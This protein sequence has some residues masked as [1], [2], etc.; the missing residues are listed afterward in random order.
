MRLTFQKYKESMAWDD[1]SR[2]IGDIV[3]IKEVKSLGQAFTYIEN[4]CLK[5]PFFH[6]YE[7]HSL[8]HFKRSGV[9]TVQIYGGDPNR[10]LEG[11]P[12]WPWMLE[13][14]V[15]PSLIGEFF[16]YD[17]KDTPP[18][19]NLNLIGKFNIVKKTL[20][21]ANKKEEDSYWRKCNK[22]KYFDGYD[23]C[24]AKGNF[25]TVTDEVKQRC[26]EKHIF[27]AEHEPVFCD[28]CN[29]EMNFK[30]FESPYEI[31]ECPICGERKNIADPDY[32]NS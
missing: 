19:E 14:P 6:D 5:I 20:E 25:G 4:Y 28:T 8:H 21:D 2:K 32:F 7:V 3:E 11:T 27:E 22:C 15:P 17:D 31:Y 16:I 1:Y 29:I 12:L 26:E 18:E 23:I 13:K 10:K 30:T 24:M 9:I